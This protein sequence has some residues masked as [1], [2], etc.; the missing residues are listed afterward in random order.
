MKLTDIL[1]IMFEDYF[2]PKAI[3]FLAQSRKKLS[4][5]TFNNNPSDVK[6]IIYLRQI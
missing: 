5:Y 2:Y 4:K 1:Y 3:N 6:R